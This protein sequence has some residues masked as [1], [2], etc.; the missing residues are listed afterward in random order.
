MESDGWALPE[1]P[2]IG[3]VREA[4]EPKVDASAAQAGGTQWTELP[5]S[6]LEVHPE[7]KRLA[8]TVESYTDSVRFVVDSPER[9][10]AQ[11]PDLVVAF[12]DRAITALART[13]ESPPAILPIATTT[14]IEPIPVEGLEKALEALCAGECRLVEC[15]V[16]NVSTATSTARAIFD[17]TLVSDEPAH[18]SEYAVRAERRHI[19]Q[20]RADG[21]VVATPAGSWGYAAAA[22][23]PTLVRGTDGLAVV[24]IAP[25][26]TRTRNWV[27]PNDTLTVTVERD[28]EVV[29]CVDTKALE[30]IGPDAP[31]TIT[32]DTATSLKTL[33]MPENTG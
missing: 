11:N 24:P 8:T 22:S 33:E 32:I 15:P 5:A 10:L 29:L 23:G 16:M 19:A 7:L 12:G 9:V 3:I 26:A 18:I 2:V 20:F 4:G 31:V 25:F 17:V 27:V 21:V 6:A 28:D 14:G 1:S 30:T 13:A